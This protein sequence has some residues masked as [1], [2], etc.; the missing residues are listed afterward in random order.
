MWVL[1]GLIITIVAFQA[2]FGSNV[3]QIVVHPSSVLTKHP[4]LRRNVSTWGTRKT[5]HFV[6]CD[7]VRLYPVTILCL[8]VTQ[9]AAKLGLAM[10]AIDVFDQVIAFL[11]LVPTL[12]ALVT[13]FQDV[14]NLQEMFCHLSLTCREHPTLL[15]AE[16]TVIFVF[17]IIHFHIMLWN[18]ASSLLGQVTRAI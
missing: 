7:L 1:I 2:N 9:I 10:S 3:S 6:S 5:S 8:V 12:S 13:L 4:D 16:R 11:C 15:T 14:M 18:S 17:I